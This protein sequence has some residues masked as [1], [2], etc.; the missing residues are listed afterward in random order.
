MQSLIDVGEGRRASGTEAASHA[1]TR[2]DLT[3]L[4]NEK[5]FLLFSHWL[6]ILCGGR[7]A[8]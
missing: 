1:A 5:V 3:M 2:A 4:C 6:L 8:E 7:K